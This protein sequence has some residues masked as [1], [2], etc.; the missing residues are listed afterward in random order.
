MTKNRAFSG[1][2]KEKKTLR[3]LVVVATKSN[4]MLTGPGLKIAFPVGRTP[5]SPRSSYHPLRYTRKKQI[6][7]GKTLSQARCPFKYFQERYSLL[8]RYS[9][10]RAFQEPSGQEI[11]QSGRQARNP[12]GGGI[13]DQLATT[14]T[15]RISEAFKRFTQKEFIRSFSSGPQSSRQKPRR[16]PWC[17]G[18][19]GDPSFQ[20]K[21]T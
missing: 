10:I 14:H 2:Q 11:R 21:P 18:F 3:R 13:H 8:L 7:E 12:S 4:L 1:N 16:R 20:R 15:L 19:S 9:E 5:F 6:W 17:H